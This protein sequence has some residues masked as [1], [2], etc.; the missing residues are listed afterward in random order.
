MSSTV[1]VGGIEVTSNSESAS[2][3]V[4]ALTPE[5]EGEKE[6]RVVVDEGKPVKQKDDDSEKV[7]EAARELGRKGGEATAKA[8]AEQ[9]DTVDKPAEKTKAEPADK[10]EDKGGKPRHDAEAR[11]RQATDQLAAERRTRQMLEERLARLE[12]AIREP[13]APQKPSSV[14]DAKPKE[15]QF[16][17]YSD[18]VEAVARWAERDERRKTQ[19][20]AQEENRIQQEHQRRQTIEQQFEHRRSNIQTRAAERWESDPALMERIDQDLASALEVTMPG[21]APSPATSIADEIGM[22]EYPIEL[23]VY[24]SEHPDDVRKMAEMPNVREIARHIAKLEEKVKDGV[25]PRENTA[26]APARA[27][28]QSSAPPPFQ[29]VKPSAGPG[30]EDVTGELSFDEFARRSGAKRR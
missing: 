13:E 4:E 8:K 28:P 9:K 14:S 21:M 6:P 17:V 19:E 27:R 12:S 24:L 23:L 1:S 10:D 7:S 20:H 3:M 29:P 26:A 2:D 25:P 22:S 30:D 16:E 5:K 18:Y 11:V 15:D